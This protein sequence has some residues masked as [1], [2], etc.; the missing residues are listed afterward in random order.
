ML[1]RRLA[2]VTES[3]PV[4]TEGNW[5]VFKLENINRRLSRRCV[6]PYAVASEFTSILYFLI[7]L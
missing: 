2:G 7:L 1:E 5:F 3:V 6:P 4:V